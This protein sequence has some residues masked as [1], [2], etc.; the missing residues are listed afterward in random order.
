MRRPAWPGDPPAGPGCIRL[1][2]PQRPQPEEGRKLF[3]V[4]ASS[5]AAVER[6]FPKPSGQTWFC[7]DRQASTYS[8]TVNPLIVQRGSDQR[9]S[10][11]NEKGPRVKG[12][13]VL[14]PYRVP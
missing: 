5:S 13:D 12:R 4:A 3:R 1:G 7:P 8:E 11:S 14:T 6:S 9:G 2:E 10:D